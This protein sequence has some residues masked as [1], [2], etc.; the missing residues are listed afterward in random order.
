MAVASGREISPD[1]A[2]MPQA[3]SKDCSTTLDMCMTGKQSTLHSSWKLKR[4][5]MLISELHI[6][7]RAKAAH[8]RRSRVARWC[9]RVGALSAPVPLLLTSPRVPGLLDCGQAL[10]QQLVE[11]RYP[12]ARLCFGGE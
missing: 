9:M 11:R 4:V 1:F 2:R 3:I 10:T 12:K 5:A 7:G 8:S 6:C